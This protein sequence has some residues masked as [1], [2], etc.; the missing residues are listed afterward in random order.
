MLIRY[1]A[2]FVRRWRR[3]ARGFACLSAK[4]PFF[5]KQKFDLAWDF[6]YIVRTRCGGILIGYDTIIRLGS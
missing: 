4:P 6:L 1:D 3:N 2:S 5:Y